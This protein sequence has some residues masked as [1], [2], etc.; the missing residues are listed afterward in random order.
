MLILFALIL[1]Y[2]AQELNSQLQIYT[3]IHKA[4]QKELWIKLLVFICNKRFSLKF[5]K[6]YLDQLTLEDTWKA[7]QLKYC[8][9]NKDED[10]NPTINNNF[11]SLKSKRKE[12]KYRNA[13]LV[14]CLQMVKDSI[15][16]LTFTILSGQPKNRWTTVSKLASGLDNNQI[17]IQL[18]RKS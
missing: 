11:S 8:F 1:Y 3:L 18:R 6:S 16:T 13:F 4:T 2:L 14:D 7:Q 17:C 10:V 9:N 15:L 5:P 12:N